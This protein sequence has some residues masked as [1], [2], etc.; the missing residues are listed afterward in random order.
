VECAFNREPQRCGHRRADR[1][2]PSRLP[3]SPS[4]SIVCFRS[5]AQNAVDAGDRAG[6]EWWDFNLEQGAVLAVAQNVG[7]RIADGA[8]RVGPA[9]NPR[10]RRSDHH[11]RALAISNDSLGRHHAS[12]AGPY[13]AIGGERSIRTTTSSHSKRVDGGTAFHPFVHTSFAKSP[14]EC[15]PDALTVAASS[16]ACGGPEYDVVGLPT[17]SGSVPSRG[18]NLVQRTEDGFRAGLRS[19]VSDVRIGAPP[20]R[21]RRNGSRPAELIVG[22][23]DHDRGDHPV[24]RSPAWSTV[25]AE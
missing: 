24:H 21:P 2:P 8:G 5:L 14:V 15:P 9:S 10:D 17:D 1:T 13:R 12:R 3:P 11:C 19:V 23:G 25:S 16:F 18:G 20:P 7:G 6:D 4:A 22:R